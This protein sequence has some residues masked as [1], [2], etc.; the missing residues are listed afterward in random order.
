MSS[1]ALTRTHGT[2][3]L[4]GHQ[5]SGPCPESVDKASGLNILL[6]EGDEAQAADLQKNL[7]DMGHKVVQVARSGQEACQLC[8]KLEPE[9]VLMDLDLP[10]MDGL[11][12]AYVIKR[13]QHLPVV[14]MA[15]QVKPGLKDE[16]LKAGVHA[17]LPKPIEDGLLARSIDIAHEQFQRLQVME[18]QAEDLRQEI[19]T[20]KLMG[21]ASGILM[22]RLEI[23]HDQAV[24][25]LHE[26]SKLKGQALMEVA[27]G[28]I[29]A[30]TVVDN[31]KPAKP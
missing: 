19:K 13:N 22:E 23:S 25:K 9:L 5:T 14:L 17:C 28:I 16:A 4:D 29:T 30:E 24:K 10:K 7:A 1:N 12:A 15:D 27:Q 11:Q 18:D 2:E 20:R 26:E 21:R 8:Q 3:D 31:S 6:A